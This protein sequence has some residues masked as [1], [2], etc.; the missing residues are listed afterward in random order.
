MK[1]KTDFICEVCGDLDLAS[2]HIRLEAIVNAVNIFTL[3]RLK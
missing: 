1:Q 3:T 2:S